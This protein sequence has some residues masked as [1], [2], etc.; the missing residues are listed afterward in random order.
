MKILRKIF[1]R[2]VPKPTWFLPMRRRL[3]TKR[4]PMCAASSRR[5]CPGP[6]PPWSVFGFSSH[7]SRNC[8][9]LTICFMPTRTLN[10]AGRFCLRRFCPGAGRKLW[11]QSAICPITASR[12]G[13]THMTATPGAGPASPI[14]AGSIMWRA[15]SMEARPGPTLRC[16]ASLPA[17]RRR[18]WTMG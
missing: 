4:S 17:A 3:R 7:G 15:G 9:S 8:G 1:C 6:I 16:A 12:R 11:W 14:I 2:D 5:P 18:T 10:A 13:S